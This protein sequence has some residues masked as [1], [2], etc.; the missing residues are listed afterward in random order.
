MNEEKPKETDFEAIAKQGLT[1]EGPSGKKS[2]I[3][4]ARALSSACRNN[5][6]ANAIAMIADRVHESFKVN[7]GGLVKA[8]TT[9][10]LNVGCC[11]ATTYLVVEGCAFAIAETLAMNQDEKFHAEVM[12]HFNAILPEIQAFCDQKYADWK[13]S[14][15]FKNQN[16]KH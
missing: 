16:P 1:I 15:D 13:A 9:E 11:E 4:T 12:A 2:A 8:G 5:P 10:K 14:D 3:L 6:I 7:M